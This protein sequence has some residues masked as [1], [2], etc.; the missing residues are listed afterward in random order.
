[1][2]KILVNLQL[3]KDDK[4]IVP[5]TTDPEYRFDK[6][7]LV[8]V[9]KDNRVHTVVT[10]TN[11]DIDYIKTLVEPKEFL[12][13]ENRIIDDPYV[14][15]S[16]I[17]LKTMTI[18]NQDLYI[19]RPIPVGYDIDKKIQE[20][21]IK[22][23]GKFLIKQKELE[24]QDQGTSTPDAL[25]TDTYVL[26]HAFYMNDSSKMNMFE[27]EVMKY[28]QGKQLNIDIL[29]D[30]YKE[31]SSWDTIKKY[32]YIPILVILLKDYRSS[33]RTSI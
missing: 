2:D 33:L 25:L 24:D 19:E 18:L 12:T 30:L 17:D 6:Y 9:D 22:W 23:Y 10:S 11:Q 27:K 1:M 7:H 32:Y 16:K 13:I 5:Y 8:T 26:G 14:K 15:D 21:R 3:E 31:F 28:V 4:N 20:A 29:M